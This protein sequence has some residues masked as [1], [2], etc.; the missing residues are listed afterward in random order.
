MQLNARLHL[1]NSINI[2]MTFIVL[3]FKLFIL[4]EYCK[5]ALIVYLRYEKNTQLL[6][7]TLTY[8]INMNKNEKQA[9]LV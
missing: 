5:A 1:A 2:K 3:P 7:I 6:L 8:S 9:M 4:L